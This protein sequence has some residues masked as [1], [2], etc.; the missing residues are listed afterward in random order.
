FAVMC[1][2]IT[3]ASS[4]A[5][6]FA[7][8]YLKQFVDLPGWLIAPLFIFGL[9]LINFRGVS[10]S[11]KTNVVLTCIELSGLLI[12]IGVGV[13][14]VINGSGDGSRLIEIDTADQTALVAI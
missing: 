8:T 11:V 7:N 10:E 12:V 2:G 3:S 13:W 6:A 5:V 4:A 9:A 14:A 1:S